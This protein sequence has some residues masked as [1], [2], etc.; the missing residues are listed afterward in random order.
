MTQHGEGPIGVHDA[1]KTHHEVPASQS[2][3]KQG[4][5]VGGFPW[6][7]VALLGMLGLAIAGIVVKL[8]LS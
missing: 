5:D 3:P 7:L 1:G 6:Q 2:I 4:M 8:I